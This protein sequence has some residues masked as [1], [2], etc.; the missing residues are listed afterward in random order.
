MKVTIIGAGNM[1]RGIGLRAVAGGNDVELI[2]RNPEDARALADELNGTG[3]GGS[4]TALA[5]GA[6]V[7]GDVVVL[8]LYYPAQEQAVAQYGPQLRGKTV[9]DISNPVDF[10]TFDRLVTPADSSAAE[11][12]AERLP[13][14]SVVKAFNTTFAKTLAGGETAG[15][16]L[17]VLIAGDDE[18]AKGK[19]A[20]LVEGGGLRPIDVGTLR[21]ARQLEHLG[22]LHISLQNRL[23][24]GFTSA[25]KLHW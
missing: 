8:A 9:V 17:D 15:Q 1:G 22:L 6:E 16:K 14:S 3:G 7:G 19:V 13:D 25:V 21:W 4:A 5:S 18:E 20:A 2:D 11:E 24:S 10:E 12:L 23:G